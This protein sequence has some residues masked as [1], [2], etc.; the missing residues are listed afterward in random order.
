M[1]HQSALNWLVSLVAILTL[2]AEGVGFFWQTEES[3]RT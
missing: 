1:K 2:I 3:Q